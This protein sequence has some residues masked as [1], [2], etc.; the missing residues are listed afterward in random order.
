MDPYLNLSWLLSYPFENNMGMPINV[1]LY[2]II[3]Q[4]KQGNTNR[5]KLF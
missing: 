2:I 1:A 5:I 3:P 4:Q